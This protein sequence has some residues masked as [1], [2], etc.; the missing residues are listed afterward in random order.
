MAALA[1]RCFGYPIFKPGKNKVSLEAP[2]YIGCRDTVFSQTVFIGAA[3]IGGAA[4]LVRQ[5][6]TKQFY[7]RRA[8]V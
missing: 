1:N 8:A 2:F 4:A 5:E 6:R 3:K 7:F